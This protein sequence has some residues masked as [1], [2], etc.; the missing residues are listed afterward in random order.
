MPDI[1]SGNDVE[2]KYDELIQNE[3]FQS[4]IKRE[5]SMMFGIQESKGEAETKKDLDSKSKFSSS[6]RVT[7]VKL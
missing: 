7:V 1:I 4:I 5:I 3:I 6:R 2:G